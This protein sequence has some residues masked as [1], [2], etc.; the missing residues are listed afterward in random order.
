MRSP[1]VPM[2]RCGSR[3]GDA[4][5]TTAIRPRPARRSTR[6][7]GAPWATS[8]ISTPGATF[9]LTDRANDLILTGGVNVYPREVERVLLLHPQVLDAG[10]IGAQYPDL[11]EHTVAYVSIDGATGGDALKRGA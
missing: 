6:R 4:S 8:A 2:E 10:V 9:Y 11:G 3:A 5:T 7:G 1:P